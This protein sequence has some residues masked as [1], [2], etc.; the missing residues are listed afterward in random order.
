[1]TLASGHCSLKRFAD[2]LLLRQAFIALAPLCVLASEP[3]D[4]QLSWRS[5]MPFKIKVSCRKNHK[6]RGYQPDRE[7]FRL[8]IGRLITLGSFLK[9][10]KVEIVLLLVFQGMYKLFGQKMCLATYIKG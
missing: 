10:K 1:M 7:N 6:A 5:G 8:C 4:Y 9:S 2:H 3:S